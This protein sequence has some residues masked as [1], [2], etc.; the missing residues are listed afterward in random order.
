M[1]G[2]GVLV[3]ACAKGSSETL[4]NGL[5]S[6]VPLQDASIDTAS[7]DANAKADVSE[8][9]CQKASDTD[10]PDLTFTDT[11]GDSHAEAGR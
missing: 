8:A 9:G 3:A 11:L 2:V 5:D 1:L 7:G 6:S 4:E 10:I